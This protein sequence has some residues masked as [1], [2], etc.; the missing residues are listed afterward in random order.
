ME[1]EYSRYVRNGI[2]YKLIEREERG[3]EEG[4]LVGKKIREMKR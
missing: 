1:G 2:A 3:R 4:K